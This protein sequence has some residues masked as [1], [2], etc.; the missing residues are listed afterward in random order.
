VR[1]WSDGSMTRAFRNPLDPGSLRRCSRYDQRLQW[2][3]SQ[4]CQLMR[5]NYIVH[6]KLF[7]LGMSVIT[8]QYGLLLPDMALLREYL[9][10]L[11]QFLALSSQ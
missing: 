8:L 6:G 3:L 1:A 11:R 10:L 4:T 7:S 9:G 5:E 2:Q